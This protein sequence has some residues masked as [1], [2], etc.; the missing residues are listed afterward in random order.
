MS[1]LERFLVFW[2]QRFYPF[3]GFQDFQFSF[4]SFVEAQNYVNNNK[5]K[6]YWSQ[7]VDS[8]NFQDIKIDYNAE[9]R[10]M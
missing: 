5:G 9:N 8:E 6:F 7:I 1:K 3:G 10:V 4:N 2:G